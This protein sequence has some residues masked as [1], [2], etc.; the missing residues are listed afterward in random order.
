[1]VKAQELHLNTACSSTEFNLTKYIPDELFDE[2]SPDLK[3]IVKS[4]DYQD[5]LAFLKLHVKKGPMLPEQ[6]FNALKAINVDTYEKVKQLLE[7]LAKRFVKLT[8][9]AQEMFRKRYTSFIFAFNDLTEEG[10]KSIKDQF[11]IVYKLATDFDFF[12]NISP[13]IEENV[14]TL[15]RHDF[16]EKVVALGAAGQNE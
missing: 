13:K 16:R 6:A 14:K 8:P 1:M 10:R 15:I 2:L 12:S 4:L 7:A 11:P 5:M 3:K 9:D